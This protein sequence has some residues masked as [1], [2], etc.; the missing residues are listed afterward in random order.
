MLISSAKRNFKELIFV[1]IHFS[2]RRNGPFIRCW[3][4][5]YAA[6]WTD[7]AGSSPYL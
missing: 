6:L 5:M 7:D 1:P 2:N 4:G 3:L